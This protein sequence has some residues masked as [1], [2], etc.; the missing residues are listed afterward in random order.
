[1]ITRWPTYTFSCNSGG[2]KSKLGFDSCWRLWGRGLLSLSEVASPSVILRFYSC[3]AP[4]P[5][6]CHMAFLYISVFLCL[7]RAFLKGHGPSDL[8]PVLFQHDCI[9][10][11]LHWLKACFPIRLHSQVQWGWVIR[12]QNY[13]LGEHSSAQNRKPLSLP[14][15]ARP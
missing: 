6:P 8:G 1:M 4:A 10:T 11:W 13:H 2:E 9:L 7:Y 15:D 5:P 3:L 12:T 14:T